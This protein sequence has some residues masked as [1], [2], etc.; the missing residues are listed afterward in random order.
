ME[1]LTWAVPL[2]ELHVEAAAVEHGADPK[3]AAE[4]VDESRPRLR[5]LVVANEQL[6]QVLV[7][8]VG[9]QSR[10]ESELVERAR[11]AG[12][13]D[14][15]KQLIRLGWNRDTVRALEH[16]TTSRMAQKLE[17]FTI[18]R[19]VVTWWLGLLVRC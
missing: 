17:C 10:D 11:T 2:V 4:C 7:T 5:V 15:R 13:F 19:L 18:V 1:D 3:R 8:D 6:E 9:Q 14:R 12:A 16:C